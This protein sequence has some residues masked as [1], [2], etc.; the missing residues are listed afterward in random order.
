[1]E[2]SPIFEKWSWIAGIGGALISLVA[3]LWSIFTR[4]KS[5]PQ[6]DWNVMDKAFNGIRIGGA[7][8]SVQKLRFKLLDRSGSGAIKIVKWALKNGNEMS[9]TYNSERNRILYMEVDW[10]KLESGK[11][12]GISR[13][14]FGKTTLKEIRELFKSNGFSYAQHMM[15]RLDDGIVTFNAFEL[16]ETPT[17]I[18]VFVTKLSHRS[19]EEINLLSDDQQVM[20][21]IGHHFKLVAVAVADES[22]LDEIWGKDK[23]YD[24]KGLPI[25]LTLH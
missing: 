15:F 24:P 12:V 1:M 23:I 17:I 21:A 7:I 5:S 10:N 9:V 14:T 25:K 3:L 20:G 13:L 2:I 11:S 18:V 16:A 6:G 8:E 22:Y 4:S 19:E